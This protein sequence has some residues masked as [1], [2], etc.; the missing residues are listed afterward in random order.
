ML[1]KGTVLNQNGARAYDWLVKYI[2]GNDF[3]AL[4]ANEL[5]KLGYVLK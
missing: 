5:R 1:H 3:K 2:N 4:L